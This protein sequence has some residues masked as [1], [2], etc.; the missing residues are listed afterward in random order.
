MLDVVLSAFARTGLEC[1]DWSV[2]WLLPQEVRIAVWWGISCAC[3]PVLREML[4]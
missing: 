1:S 2:I 4:L 3:L